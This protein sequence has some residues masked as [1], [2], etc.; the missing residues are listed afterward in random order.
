MKP[1]INWE[2]LKRIT[3]DFKEPVHTVI[4]RM[5]GLG[6]FDTGTTGMDDTGLMIKCR[7]SGRFRLQPFWSRRGCGHDE[8]LGMRERIWDGPI[9][10]RGS[11]EPNDNGGT[12][13]SVL[14]VRDRWRRFYVPIICWLFGIAEWLLVCSGL[15]LDHVNSKIVTWTITA[16]VFTVLGVVALFIYKEEDPSDTI[17]ALEAEFDKRMESLKY[18]DK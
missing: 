12:R 11:I 9:S 15:S 4:E 18:W 14:I 2:V 1:K 6:R 3:V 17:R 16:I 10:L 5:R 7:R 13:V 8:S